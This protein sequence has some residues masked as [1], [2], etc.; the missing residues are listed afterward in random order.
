MQAHNSAVSTASN[1]ANLLF[2]L[3]F[4]QENKTSRMWTPLEGEEGAAL[5]HG[6]VESHFIFAE[7]TP[8]LPM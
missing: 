1:K 2:T 6:V 3:L 5:F 4:A 7:L 8:D